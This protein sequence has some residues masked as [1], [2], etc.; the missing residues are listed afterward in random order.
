[1]SK[2]AGQLKFAAQ[3]RAVDYRTPGQQRADMTKQEG[4]SA[5]RLRCSALLASEDDTRE[6]RIVRVM[7]FVLNCGME[8]SKAML[9]EAAKRELSWFPGALA[10]MWE[11]FHNAPLDLE[12]AA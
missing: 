12:R 7:A 6:Q 4:P 9:F 11:G 5:W 2:T 1:M 10:E 3:R 8:P